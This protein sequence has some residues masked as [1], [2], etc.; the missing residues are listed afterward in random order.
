MPPGKVLTPLF[1]V[2]EGEGFPAVGAPATQAAP[3]R[4]GRRR[5]GDASRSS[6]PI[7]GQARSAVRNS[8]N[9]GKAVRETTAS[10]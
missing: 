10:R 9:P 7:G 2:G 4:P 3:L 8:G 6:A 5:P 1:N